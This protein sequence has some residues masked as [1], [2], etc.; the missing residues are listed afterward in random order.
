ML[1]RVLT[2]AELPEP[3]G[4]STEWTDEI[5]AEDTSVREC[6]P[7]DIGIRQRAG[8]I[9]M[10]ENRVPTK[11]I[12]SLYGGGV[13]SLPGATRNLPP[14]K[15]PTAPAL[16]ADGPQLGSWQVAVV[17]VDETPAGD[18]SGWECPRA[19]Q[20]RQRPIDLSEVAGD[21]LPVL[22][23]G[24]S[25]LAD[26]VNSVGPVGPCGMP[27]P[28][29]EKIHEPLQHTVLIQADPAGRP[30]AVGTLS[31]SDCYH[32]RPAG[33]YVGPDVCCTNPE[34]VTHTI[35]V[36]ADPAGQDASAVGTP[37]PSDCYPAGPY[38]AGGPV[39][40][41]DCLQ[42][43][44]S[45]EELILDHA[46]PAGQH[47]VVLDTAE[48]LGDAVVENILDGR[49]MEGITCPELLEYSL[50][51]LD[52]TLDG[53]LISDWEPEASPVPDATLDS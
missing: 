33:P 20:N 19:E 8:T 9:G 22:P 3:P 47:A 28:Y 48:S 6:P 32:V 13:R 23:A 25:P 52:A 38:V 41:D 24:G 30:S 1:R 5:M 34:P 10:S 36:H 50:R 46:D 4:I 27:S 14:V 16:L 37:S 51:L 40:P 43:L 31:P 21:V 42:T 49:P 29:A 18:A 39:G 45:Y 26:L 35:L 15:F 44:V 7:D 12:E 17:R 53:G 2:T 11:N